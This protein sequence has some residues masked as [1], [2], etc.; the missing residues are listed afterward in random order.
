M[1]NGSNSWTFLAHAPLDFRLS[2]N[3]L[4]T[5]Q[6]NIKHHQATSIA[7]GMNL[8]TSTTLLLSPGIEGP[9][10]IPH[11]LRPFRSTY[12]GDPIVAGDPLRTRNWGSDLSETSAPASPDL[13]SNA[14]EALVVAG[15]SCGREGKEFKESVFPAME[16]NCLEAVH[17]RLH[18]SWA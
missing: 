6:H 13:A 2:C 17:D 3:L 10:F 1:W 18:F 16:E 5:N 8:K 14:C 11:P 4:A 12:R 9:S 7:N 15:P